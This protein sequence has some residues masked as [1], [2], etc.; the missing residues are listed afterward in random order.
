[1]SNYILAIDQGTTSS[2]A[3]V[4]DEDLKIRGISQREI[5]N[6]FRHPGWVEMDANEIW[7]SVEF[8]CLNAVANA[9]IS[10]KELKAIGITNQRETTI[11]WDKNTGMPVFLSQTMVVSRWLVMPIAFNSLGEMPALATAFRQTNSTL[12]QISL[13]SISTQPGCRKVF[14]IS[15]WEMPLIFRSSSK[16]MA[17]EL[18]VP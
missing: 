7:T 2:R 13:A 16:T 5:P 6:T 9:G 14:G 12:V 1:M 3:I 15:R 11:V 17:R 4:F 8:V 10:P 18:V